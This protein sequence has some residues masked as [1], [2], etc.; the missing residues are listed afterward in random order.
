MRNMTYEKMTHES[1]PNA[2]LVKRQSGKRYNAH[3]KGV[4]ELKDT[5]K[6]E[7]GQCH[8]NINAIDVGRWATRRLNVMHRRKAQTVQMQRTM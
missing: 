8:S 2:M 1:V 6:G 7:N 5:S 3:K 4:N